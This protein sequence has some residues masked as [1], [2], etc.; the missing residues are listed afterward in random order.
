MLLA[1]ATL[2]VFI[3]AKVNNLSEKITDSITIMIK[4]VWMFLVFVM[5]I[6]KISLFFKSVHLRPVLVGV[7]WTHIPRLKTR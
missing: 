2:L 3:I 6:F 5:R 4:V 7:S 1:H